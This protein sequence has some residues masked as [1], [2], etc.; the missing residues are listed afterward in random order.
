MVTTC[1]NRNRQ[2][3]TTSP[4]SDVA[5]LRCGTAAFAASGAKPATCAPRRVFSVVLRPRFVLNYREATLGFSCAIG[6]GE[7]D[8]VSICS[9]V[10]GI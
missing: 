6:I 8:K 10:E 5:S 2:K 9:V 1:P 7:F 4:L 3:A